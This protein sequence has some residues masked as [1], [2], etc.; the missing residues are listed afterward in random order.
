MAREG[1]TSCFVPASC[2]AIQ[3][4]TSGIPSA[5]TI[6]SSRPEIPVKAPRARAMPRRGLCAGAF[7]GYKSVS[8]YEDVCEIGDHAAWIKC[9][10]A[11]AD[12]PGDGP[13]GTTARCLETR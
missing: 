9:L 8:E 10:A 11:R 3:I 6:A 7:I 13:Q 4:Q 5:V 2:E 1:V 12:A